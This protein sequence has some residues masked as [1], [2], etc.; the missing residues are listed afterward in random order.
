MSDSSTNAAASEFGQQLREMNEELLLSSVHQ[1]ELTE[2]AE[3][4]THQAEQAT[5][6]AERALVHAE[7]AEAALLVSEAR[8][9]AIAENIPQLAWMADGDGRVSWFNQ[10]WLD[11]T[12]TTLED[13]LA[14]G[15]KTVHHPDHVDAVAEKFERHLREGRDWEDTF[16]LRGRDGKY[17]WF[18]S[19]MTAIYDDGGKVQHFFG[20][21]TDVTEQRRIEDALRENQTHLAESQMRLAMELS[22]TQKLQE[23]S[24]ELIGEGDPKS[25]YAKIVDAAA[26]IMRSQCASLQIYYPGAED[27]GEFRLLAHLGFNS[28]TAKYLERVK[29]SSRNISGAVLDTGANVSVSNIEASA[30]LAGSIDL[31]IFIQNGIHSAQATPLISRT[32]Q[33]LGVICTYWKL[34]H[35]PVER[36]LRLLDVL[37]RQAT[38]L[39]ERS[40]AEAAVRESETR[41]RRLFWNNMV[42][43]GV[44]TPSG[45]ITEANDALLDLI[46]YSRQELEARSI[47]WTELTPPEY[48][49][50]DAG[51]VAELWEHGYCTPYEKVYIHKDGHQ[52]P[53][54]IGGGRFDENFLS[55]G[56]F[57]AVDITRRR[58]A[59]ILVETQKQALEMVL[60]GRP[61][62]EVLRFLVEI[63]EER[64]AGSSVGSIMLLDDEGHL[65]NAASRKLPEEYLKAID[66][67]AADANVG[68]CS[69]A[70]AISKTVI[71]PDIAADPKWANFMHLPLGLGLLAAWSMPISAAD[72]R[73]LGTFG[74]Y[75]REKRE[76]T[77]LE[78]RTVE[79]LAKTAALAIERK[80]AEEHLRQSEERYRTLFNSIDE[81]FCI[82]ELIFDVTDEPIDYRFLETSPSF[83]KQTGIKDASG[84][85]MREMY[86]EHEQHWFDTYG[87]IALTGEP[88]RFENRA[89][90]LNSWYDVY[91]FR[92]G[93]PKNRQVAILFNNISERKRTEVALRKSEERL[94]L[95]SES[96]TD[97]AIFIAD[98]EGLVLSW[99]TGAEK[100]F[101]YKAPEIIGTSAD[102][103]FTPEDRENDVP[104]QEMQTARETGRASDERWHLRK[105]GSR[106]YA[107][108]VM[109]P[110]FDQDALVGYAKIARD[111]TESKQIQEEL[112]LYRQ[113]L[114][115]LVAAR[116]TELEESNQSLRQEISDRRRAEEERV[117]LLRRIVTTQED[118]R[119]R[120]ARDM[121]DSLGQQLT[122]LRLKIATLISNKSVDAHLEKEIGGLQEAA[123]L[124]DAEIGFLAWEL[125]PPALDDLGFVAATKNFVSEWSRHYGIVA[126]LHAANLEEKR[127]APGIE[128]NLYRITQEALNNVFKHAEAKNV[129]I[130][131][132][133]RKGDVVLVI[134]DD[135]KGFEPT[136]RPNSEAGSRLGLVGMRERA[137]T[138]GGTLEIES[139]PG[140]GTT[141]FARVP[142]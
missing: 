24:T 108:G 64:G 36:D 60:E 42:A 53:I 96:F 125:R 21:N 40:Q 51:A 3:H 82:I 90:Q 122:A 80:H 66:G 92:F 102:K 141:I 44:F 127:L 124:L 113:Q 72:G 56:I 87:R 105:D 120:I 98:I 5:E 54:L 140:K 128:T 39:I 6:K 109:A 79:I 69:A 77:E 26:A 75:F 18:L 23:V 134:E 47:R 99:N 107:S 30:L 22:A 70:A 27:L 35:Q 41:F 97:Y 38:D 2:Q 104:N 76:P 95:M 103:L 71:T 49:Q 121:H 8:F 59:E 65:H 130:V 116:T 73:I 137:E 126:E 43:M 83:E 45:N 93:D 118:E 89:D 16:P 129:N 132:E 11:Y 138:V 13:N 62:A 55:G 63:V 85:R 84:K 106:F 33:M 15:W 20:T 136:D 58:H 57:F 112:I 81:G 131:I 46:G 9:R 67:I 139:G 119:R 117:G 34:P 1:H 61:L 88:A 12:G 123:A 32:G 17:R 100:I 19:R 133:R 48:A 86:P 25:L 115:T 91:A 50:L 68:T 94:R 4:A 110:L 74:T 7:R 37:A 142:G 10:G 135:G 52:I 101:G 14:E 78:I 29:P 28:R 31:P 111:L 114:E